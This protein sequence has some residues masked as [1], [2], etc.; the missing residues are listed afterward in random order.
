[1]PLNRKLKLYE[2]LRLV[3]TL[4]LDS[5]EEKFED[6]IER[7]LSTL[8]EIVEADRIIF[9]TLSDDQRTYR[10]LY[11]THHHSF[12]PLSSVDL[13][14]SL[15]K[16]RWLFNELEEGKSLIITDLKQLP[17]RAKGERDFFKNHQLKSLVG[18]PIMESGKVLSFISIQKSRD[19]S[20]WE[21]EVVEIISLLGN[22]IR[23]SEAKEELERSFLHMKQMQ[24][25]LLE[26]AETYIAIDQYQLKGAVESSLK[27]M[28]EF[29]KADRTY[30]FEYDFKNR[31]TINRAEWCADGIS[32][33]IDNLQEIK[34]E[35]IPEWVANHSKG[36][37]YYIPD[38]AQL[39]FNDPNG[40]R[41]ILERQDVKSLITV[42][43][44]QGDELLGFVGIDSVRY[45]RI[46]NEREVALISFFAQMI[47]NVSERLY[48]S[49]PAMEQTPSPKAELSPDTTI[50]KEL[51]EEELLEVEEELLESEAP[52]EQFLSEVSPVSQLLLQKLRLFDR[53]LFE[54]NIELLLKVDNKIP[55]F[56]KEMKEQLLSAT[57]E[58]IFKLSG[59]IESG[60]ISIELESDTQEI[61][62]SNNSLQ[63]TATA[64]P[65]CKSSRTRKKKKINRPVREWREKKNPLLQKVIQKDL[66]TLTLTLEEITFTSLINPLKRTKRKCKVLIVDENNLV[67]ELLS[68][69]LTNWKIKHKTASNGIE[70]LKI[71]NKEEQFNIL[72][73]AE[74]MSMIKGIDTVNLL[75]NQSTFKVEPPNIFLMVR[76]D[77]SKEHYIRRLIQQNKITIIRKPLAPTQLLRELERYC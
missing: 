21:D 58:M 8:L 35:P 71:L 34:L 49:A 39:P 5:E 15:L 27:K 44:M 14:L 36:E 4:F 20:E 17:V 31:I 11:E 18:V 56:A 76:D 38:V 47:V 70:A 57:E 53:E 48:S 69:Y 25:L 30:I 40:V 16:Y 50:G 23:E 32:V 66:F 51:L 73:L 26:I 42:P 29:I 62:S 65:N 46:Y 55:S 24:S 60:T 77:Y 12:T 67:R 10:A 1:M 59:E 64:I 75:L 74:E 63:I 54:S 61:S 37:P 19:E 45:H 3:A 2:L 43:M 28:G 7:I 72:F 13:N 41:A 22:L 6:K 33:Q 9:Y 52:Q 68:S